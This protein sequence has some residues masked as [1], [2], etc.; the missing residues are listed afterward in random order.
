MQ[1]LDV[2]AIVTLLRADQCS[3]LSRLRV[4]EGNQRVGGV[5]RGVEAPG[6][7]VARVTRGSRHGGEAAVATLTQGLSHNHTSFRIAV[8]PRERERE[9]F[10]FEF[11]KKLFIR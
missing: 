2:V 8:K 3:F 9:F 7:T 11:Y 1:R 10:F 5:V 6:N 4:V